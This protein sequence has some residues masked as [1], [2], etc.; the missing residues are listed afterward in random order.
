MDFNKINAS[1]IKVYFLFIEIQHIFH[2]WTFGHIVQISNKT[3]S[4][5]KNCIVKRK[6]L[7]HC[8]FSTAACK[9]SI[10]ATYQLDSPYYIWTLSGGIGNDLRPFEDDILPD[11]PLCALIR[12]YAVTRS[13]YNYK[14]S[15]NG[16]SLPL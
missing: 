13:F 1:S 15:L 14:Y 3:N 11:H 6:L 12:E 16:S 8:V 10:M 7:R 2:C 5:N 9:T 4:K